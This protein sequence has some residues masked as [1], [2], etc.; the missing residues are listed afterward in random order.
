MK[1]SNLIDTILDE[2]STFHQIYDSKIQPYFSKQCVDVKIDDQG[3]TNDSLNVDR[4]EEESSISQLYNELESIKIENIFQ[5]KH[6]TVSVMQFDMVP[7]QNS[8]YVEIIPDIIKLATL[9]KVTP[10]WGYNFLELNENN[11]ED[12]LFT[13]ATELRDVEEN[14]VFD[15]DR[16]LFQQLFKTLK[17]KFSLS[18]KMLI[19]IMAYYYGDREKIIMISLFSKRGEVV[20]GE[21]QR[22]Q[23]TLEVKEK[24]KG[25]DKGSF[26]GNVFD[27]EQG[28]QY[29]GF[30][31]EELMEDPQVCTE[32]LVIKEVTGESSSS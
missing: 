2:I 7:G 4:I 3:P 13:V 8:N 26:L 10:Y 30:E 9:E 11:E 27:C 31:R 24:D 25:K 23:L 19:K 21:E 5:Q 12:V 16:T 20:E 6:L 32:T 22:G 17:D 1:R 18:T 28:E 29:W 14:F 15:V